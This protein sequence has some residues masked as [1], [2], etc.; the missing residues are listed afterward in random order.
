MHE[1]IK[2]HEK[3]LPFLYACKGCE[4]RKLLDFAWLHYMLE[5][6]GGRVREMPYR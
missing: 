5:G 4:Y 3:K 6:V 2:K 1:K